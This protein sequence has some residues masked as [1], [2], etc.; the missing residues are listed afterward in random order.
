[1]TQFVATRSNAAIPAGAVV[2]MSPDQV[3]RRKHLVVADGDAHR[4]IHP[5]TFKAGETVGLRSGA[6]LRKDAGFR[7]VEAAVA[8]PAPKKA[9][10]KK[11][12][13]ADE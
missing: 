12:A 11:A 10:A 3:R 8:K 2:A 7:S 9:A 13:K 4:A 6:D 1:M 5:L